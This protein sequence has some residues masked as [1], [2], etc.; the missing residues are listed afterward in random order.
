MA[1]NPLTILIWIRVGREAYKLIREMIVIEPRWKDIKKIRYI[2]EPE[3]GRI[4]IKPKKEKENYEVSQ[5][6]SSY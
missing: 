5:E 2:I 4:K 3:K 6:T 1:L